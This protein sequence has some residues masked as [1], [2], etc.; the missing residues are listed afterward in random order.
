MGW[1]RWLHAERRNAI[2]GPRHCV[3]WCFHAT[4]PE[5]PSK[6]PAVLKGGRVSGWL[7]RFEIAGR[8]ALFP[9]KV[10]E[11]MMI[12]SLSAPS[13]PLDELHAGWLA[14]FARHRQIVV[15]DQQR[16]QLVGRRKRRSLRSRRR[17]RTVRDEWRSPRRRRPRRILSARIATGG[18]EESR[19]HEFIS[20][21]LFIVLIFVVYPILGR[22]RKTFAQA[23]PRGA[24]VDSQ[25]F[26]GGGW[27]AWAAD[28]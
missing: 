10:P 25:G 11:V 12:G 16:Y 14:F 13:N 17:A 2:P 20:V 22:L 6:C 23:M 1:G 15:P 24:S 3:W 19:M 27:E 4:T 21:V 5:H 18:S 8:C 26:R 9:G 28:G 7:L